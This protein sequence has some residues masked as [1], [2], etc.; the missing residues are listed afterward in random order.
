VHIARDIL[1]RGYFLE[2][3]PGNIAL[4]EKASVVSVSLLLIKLVV[5]EDTHC[6]FVAC[7]EQNSCLARPN[8]IGRV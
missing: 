5:S 6:V 3:V 7:V 4:D 2:M 8:R 1:C